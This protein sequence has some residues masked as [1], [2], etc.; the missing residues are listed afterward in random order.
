[1]LSVLSWV[2]VRWAARR[3]ERKRFARK[4]RVAIK[5]R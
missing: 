1:M 5:G 4:Y 2:G 3:L